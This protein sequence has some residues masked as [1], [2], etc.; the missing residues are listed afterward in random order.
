MNSFK[1]TNLE[2]NATTVIKTGAGVLH[3][4]TINTIGATANTVV[5]YDNT[6][7]SGTIIA[8]IDG[9]IAAAPTRI[10]DLC[11]TTGLTVIIA[12]GTAAKITVTWE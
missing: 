1:Y 11:F 6:A 7:A 3:S 12:S 2:A 8:S 10:Y 9:T 4:I 5:V